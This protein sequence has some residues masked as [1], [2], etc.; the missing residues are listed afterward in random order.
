MSKQLCHHRVLH[1][2][3]TECYYILM[4]QKVIKYWNIFST[5]SFILQMQSTP[6]YSTKTESITGNKEDAE[7]LL[8]HS[9]SL[10]DELARVQPKVLYCS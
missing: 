8:P 2:G 6:F 3:T 5:K 10:P 1:S 7:W 9:L 4:T